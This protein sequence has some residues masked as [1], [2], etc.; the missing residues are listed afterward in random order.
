MLLRTFLKES[1][2]RVYIDFI[3]CLRKST[4]QCLTFNEFAG[5][6]KDDVLQSRVA[7]FI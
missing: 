6:H 2:H 4:K 5:P 7:P 1:L 3:I